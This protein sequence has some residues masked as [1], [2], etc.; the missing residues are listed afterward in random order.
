MKIP[1]HRNTLEKAKIINTV[2]P[3]NEISNNLTRNGRN[4]KTSLHATLFRHPSV[5]LECRGSVRTPDP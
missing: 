1:M 5:T 2:Q 4:I 3:M